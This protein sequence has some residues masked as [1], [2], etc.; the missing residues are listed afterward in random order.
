MI[1]TGFGL[2]DDLVRG[3]PLAMLERHDIVDTS[4]LFDSKFPPGVRNA[5]VVMHGICFLSHCA[6]D[7][8]SP[9]IN[10]QCV[11]QAREYFDAFILEHINE[12]I[13]NVFP[14]WSQHQRLMVAL[15]C[16]FTILMN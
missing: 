16:I 11:C 8:L 13:Q 14:P 15:C 2:V 7:V 6:H 9:T 3:L 5:Q 1:D 12:Y 10:L 4:G